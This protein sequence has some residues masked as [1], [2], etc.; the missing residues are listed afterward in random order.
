MHLY[1]ASH[2]FPVASPPI[3]DGIIVIDAGRIVAVGEADRV[4]QQFAGAEVIDLGEAMIIP[5][6]VNTHTHL[7]LTP[8]AQLGQKYDPQRSF[9]QWIK[10]L[11]RQ[12]RNVPL[13]VQAEGA[14]EGCQMLLT[15]GT[16]AVGDISNT[17]A[18]LEPLLASGLY[19]ILYHEV[20]NPDPARAPALFYEAR[21]QVRRWRGEYGEERIRFGVTLHTPFTVS[22]ELF[23][24]VLPWTIEENVPLCIHVAESPAES[25]YLM[26]GTGEIA[27]ELY[28]D[29]SLTQ[30]IVPPGCSPVMY[31][32]RLGILKARPLLAHGVQVD[33]ADVKLLAER[34]APVA[35]CPRSNAL[36]NCGRMPI[37]LYQ[38]AGALVSPGTDSLSSS[39]SLNVWEEAASAWKIHRAAGVPLDPHDLLRM[40]TLD[41]ARALGFAAQLGSLEPGKLA[42]L[43]AGRFQAMSANQTPEEMLR[44]LWLG[45]VVVT[46]T[47]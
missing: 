28:P 27:D 35:H 9:V 34:G 14:H 33:R 45:N 7:E 46:N 2:I 15:C 20:F 29:A 6:C 19:G 39:P 37:E 30:L 4:R 38:E 1:H 32:D 25:E 36:L 5:Q 23:R 8:L 24:L 16:S 10:E 47:L 17:H 26:Y 21:E 43:A 3:T 44:Q 40:C 13:D 41:G 18:S 31:L 22:A 12:W 42:K 11:V